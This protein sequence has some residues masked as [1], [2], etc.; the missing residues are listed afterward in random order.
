MGGAVG[1][2]GGWGFRP[3]LIFA[4]DDQGIMDALPDLPL[5]KVVGRQF[6]GLAAQQALQQVPGI[7]HLVQPRHVARRYGIKYPTAQDALRRAR[8][9]GARG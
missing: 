5:M 7:L 4:A 9:A 6:H 2:P 1:L 8:E 3:G